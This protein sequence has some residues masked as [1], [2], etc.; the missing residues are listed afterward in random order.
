MV[1]K[2]QLKIMLGSIICFLFLK[3]SLRHC[4]DSLTNFLNF[5]FEVDSWGP[6]KLAPLV[7]GHLGPH[8]T[9]PTVNWS[10]LSQIFPIAHIVLIFRL[11]MFT[12][13]FTRGS[14]EGLV[15]WWRW[16]LHRLI[17][18]MHCHNQPV[19]QN[20]MKIGWTS[21]PPIFTP[22]F[23]VRTRMKVD[24]GRASRQESPQ[25]R[26]VIF[27]RQPYD[28]LQF[29]NCITNFLHTKSTFMIQ[30]SWLGDSEIANKIY[31]RC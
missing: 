17:M 20:W 16:P 1:E 9:G 26:K 28:G 7:N 14:Q 31:V 11:V 25:M 8:S 18:T 21:F 19:P 10:N 6:P 29:A 5:I 3:T 23:I 4:T 22:V 27:A 24:L 12:R 13:E 30:N 2:V 15:T